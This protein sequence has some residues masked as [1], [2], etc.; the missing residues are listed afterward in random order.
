MLY[1]KGDI[2]TVKA[3]VEFDTTATDTDMHVKIGSFATAMVELSDVEPSR[4]NLVRGDVV[5]YNEVKMTVIAVDGD[6]VWVRNMGGVDLIVDIQMLV[7][8]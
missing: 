6:N 7:R 1:R 2:V 3:V 4:L 8:Q 5:F